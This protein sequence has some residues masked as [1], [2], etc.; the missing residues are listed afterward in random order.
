MDAAILSDVT[1]LSQSGRRSKSNGNSSE[2]VN[3]SDD[4]ELAEN[5][6]DFASEEKVERNLGDITSVCASPDETDPTTSSTPLSKRRD[7]LNAVLKNYKQARLKRSILL[8][9]QLLDCAKQDIEIRKRIID[10]MDK[11]DKE[12]YENIKSL[13]E[14]MD[15]LTNSIAD[16]F[17]HL[18]N[19][20]TS[21]QQPPQ[22]HQQNHQF[23]LTH[24]HQQQ[25][26]QM[27]YN[28]SS[29]TPQA[30][31]APWGIHNVSLRYNSIRAPKANSVKNLQQDSSNKTQS[32]VPQ[33]FSSF[34][35][36]VLNNEDGNTVD[37]WSN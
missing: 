20:M 3:V 15:K 23:Y 5:S 8:D 36:A 27:S 4:S 17:S 13:S 22:H 14:N 16:V 26:Q 2:S 18:R 19:L 31:S 21:Q 34:T 9:S 32:V 24:H 6:E 33:G 30:P 25:Q 11:M 29:Y 35:D 7:M 28:F 10:Q 37:I 12:Y 1:N